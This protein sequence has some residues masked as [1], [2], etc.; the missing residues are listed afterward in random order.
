MT[1]MI[2]VC[3]NFRCPPSTRSISSGRV[4]TLLNPKPQVST[5]YASH[6]CLFS[7]TLMLSISSGRVFMTSSQTQSKLLHTWIMLVIVKQHLMQ[8]GR[9]LGPTEYL[10]QTL[11][12]IRSCWWSQFGNFR[13]QNGTG[14][15]GSCPSG[16]E[17][18]WQKLSILT[19][20]DGH[21]E[22]ESGDTTPCRMT[23]V[24]SHSH[25]QNILL[26]LQPRVG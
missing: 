25:A 3:G 7:R 2:Q 18:I 21:V 14:F 1:N 16:T 17:Q 4:F 19:Q 24:T 10:F 5:Q 22:Q 20:I 23:G 6:R 15:S 13:S 8:I 12:A 11:V 26:G 9:I